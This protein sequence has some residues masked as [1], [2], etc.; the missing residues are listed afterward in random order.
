MRTYSAH[1]GRYFCILASSGL[2]T[3]TVPTRQSVK[4]CP[5][6]KVEKHPFF[7]ISSGKRLGMEARRSPV[8]S[9]RAADWYDR[10]WKAAESHSLSNNDRERTAKILSMIPPHV[11]T[12]LDVGC[13]DGRVTNTVSAKGFRVFAVDI[14]AEGL[15]KVNGLRILG[16]SSHL[17]LRRGYFD[18]V[19]CSEVL[20]HL[21]VADFNNTVEELKRVSKRYVLVTVPCEERLDLH[22][23][24]CDRCLSRFHP[25]RHLRSFSRA[26]VASLFPTYKALRMETSGVEH[27]TSS[28]LAGFLRL[29]SGYNISWDEALAECPV[30]G[31]LVKIRKAEDSLLSFVIMKL[32]AWVS[33]V[34]PKKPYHL[35][36]LFE[37]RDLS[38]AGEG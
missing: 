25:V 38:G 15:Q 1:C 10:K 37:R 19:I 32:M 33:R 30:C 16:D 35:E 6:D 3:R 8:T 29:A 4:L 28:I 36:V 2:S 23:I 21:A 9:M 22:L 26:Q 31:N 17:P 20:E 27:H 34:A 18:L 7:I 5:T 11:R 13:G 24:R 14:S 12:I